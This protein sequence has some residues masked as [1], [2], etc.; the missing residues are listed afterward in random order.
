MMLT[1]RC[2]S[3]QIRKIN[4]FFHMRFVFLHVFFFLMFTDCKKTAEEEKLLLNS[5]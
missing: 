2:E 5:D 4:N 3:L 1:N